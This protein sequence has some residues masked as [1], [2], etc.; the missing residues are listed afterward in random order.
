VA[1]QQIPGVRQGDVGSLR[2]GIRYGHRGLGTETVSL[3]RCLAQRLQVQGVCS[4]QIANYEIQGG[5]LFVFKEKLKLLKAYLKEWNMEVFGNVF[6][7]GD[8]IQKKDT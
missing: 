8:E 2:A 4:Q 7:Q 6:Q 5:G 3:F 1:G